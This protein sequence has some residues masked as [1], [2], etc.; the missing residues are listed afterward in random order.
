MS[1]LWTGAA[2]ARSET[3]MVLRGSMHLPFLKTKETFPESLS[4]ANAALHWLA[5]LAEFY[6]FDRAQA[7]AAIGQKSLTHRH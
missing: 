6:S 7:I 4:G 1:D 2:T 5:R 3:S